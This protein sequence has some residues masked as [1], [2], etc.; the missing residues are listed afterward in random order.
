MKKIIVPAALCSLFALNSLPTFAESTMPQGLSAGMAWDQGLSAVLEIEDQYRFTVGNDGAAFDY[1][2]KK[3]NFNANTLLTW[4]VGVGGWGS[5]DDD[6]FGPRVPLGVDWAFSPGWN[7]YGQVHPELDLDSGPD[8]QIG[9]A[10][11]VTY[12]F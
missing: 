7:M 4:Y 3:G 12:S 11:G 9:A 10:L 5:W 8:L 1:L 6:E 2:F